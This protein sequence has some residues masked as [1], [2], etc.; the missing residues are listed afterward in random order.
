MPG[1]QSDQMGKNGAPKYFWLNAAE[2]ITLYLRYVLNILILKFTGGTSNRRM[3][4]L[5]KVGVKMRLIFIFL[6]F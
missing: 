1:N 5:L 4:L 6:R 2:N 3:E